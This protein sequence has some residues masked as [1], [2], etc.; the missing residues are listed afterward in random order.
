MEVHPPER[1]CDCSECS[2]YFSYIHEPGYI[3]SITKYNSLQF[4]RKYMELD[5][6]KN[7]INFIDQEIS[8]LSNFQN[9]IQGISSY[10]RSMVEAG[11][12]RIDFLNAIR[13][14][15]ENLNNE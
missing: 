5:N 1:T 3:E 6:I 11:K 9:K 14:T 7:Q 13:K 2:E 4:I 12:N 15:L 8:I 10:D